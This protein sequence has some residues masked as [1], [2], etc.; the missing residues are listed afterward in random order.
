MKRVMVAVLLLIT[1]IISSGCA[2]KLHIRP[3]T[4]I[5]LGEEHVFQ[6]NYTVNQRSI[7]YV[8]QPIIKVRDYWVNRYVAQ[9]S[10]R[11]SHNFVVSGGFVEINGQAEMDY[12]IAGE[13]T[14]DGQTYTVLEIPG[15]ANVL[16]IKADGSFHNVFFRTRPNLAIPVM[17]AFTATPSDLKF[18]SSEGQDILPGKG[19]LNYEL[20]YGGTDSKMITITY[21]EYTA[22]DLARSSFYQN[23]IFDSKQ[24]TIRFRNTVIKVHSATN[25]KIDFTVISDELDQAK[26]N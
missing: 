3:A 11:A 17:G 6:K 2:T 7:A 23:L 24:E 22:E 12:L 1:I 19:K 15:I 14:L 20:I 18:I 26:E 9:R 21:R 13:T 25:E 10:M 5:H 4:R 8:G 16:L